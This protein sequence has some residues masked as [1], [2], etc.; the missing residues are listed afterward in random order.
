MSEQGPSTSRAPQPGEEENEISFVD[1]FKPWCAN[2]GLK[3]ETIAAIYDHGFDSLRALALMLDEDIPPLNLQNKGQIRLLQAAIAKAKNSS[4]QGTCDKDLPNPVASG[5]ATPANT[6]ARPA[7][8]PD[9]GITL[10]SILNQLPHD[11]NRPQPAASFRPEFDPTFHLM[12]GKLPTGICKALDILD[13]VG[14]SVKFDLGDEQVISEVGDNN[15]LILK[16][17]C[18]KPKYESLTVWQW[19][20]GAVRIQD[21]LVRTGKLNSEID[22]RQYWGYTCKILELNS[23]FEWQSILEYDREYRKNQARFNFAW[24]TEIP[25]LSS[26]Q[27]KDKKANFQPANSNKKSKQFSQSTNS[28]QGKKTPQYICRDFN[29][30]KCARTSCK[31][32]HI[33]SVNNC[34]KD[35]PAFKH[36]GDQS[37]NE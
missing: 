27:L 2:H 20:L 19:A 29:R 35:H 4:A 13:F 37:K 33:C 12:A 26:V 10:D 3:E 14:M 18:K 8:Q 16:T 25:H 15:S 17:N 28:S 11:N 31:Y 22:K 24:G 32:Q 23:R 30:D 36:D 6:P 1:N 9:L 21:E 5:T 34:Y 7:R